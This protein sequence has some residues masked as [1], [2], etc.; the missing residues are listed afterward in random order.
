MAAI[1]EMEHLSRTFGDKTALADICC[2]IDRGEVFGLLGPSGAGKTTLIKILTGQLTATS[3]KA[4]V[5][6]KDCSGLPDE[7]YR[8]IGMVLDNSGLYP[9]LSCRDNLMLFARIHRVEKGKIGEML[10][11]VGLTEAEKTP[12]GKLSKGMRQRLVLVKAILH[13]PELLFL[14]EPTSGLDPAASRS[15]HELLFQLRENGTT[16]FLTTHH[17]EEAEKLC[18][19]TALLNDGVIVEKGKPEE[20]CRKYN[21]KKQ[22]VIRTRD[23]EVVSLNGDSADAEKIAEYFRRDEVETIHSSEPTLETVFLE[24]TGRRLSE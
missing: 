3:G 22:V 20:L 6:Q 13:S 2:R 18:D 9:K 11:R 8:R 15:I 10:E 5:F 14:D 4:R 7:T 19:E 24:V 16:I 1:I 21:K 23:G 12:A 17:M